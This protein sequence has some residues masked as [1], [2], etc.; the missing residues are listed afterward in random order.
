LLNDY[1]SRSWAGLTKSFYGKRWSMF[2]EAVN[3]ALDN[4]KE[5]D[6]DQFNV[7][8]D[9]VTTFEKYWWEQCLGSYNSEPVGDSKAIATKLIEK[10]DKMIEL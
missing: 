9:A 1:A 10:Y 6:E 7:Y 8:K 3:N 4:G 5:F 2:F